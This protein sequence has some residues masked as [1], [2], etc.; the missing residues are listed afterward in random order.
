MVDILIHSPTIDSPGKVKDDYGLRFLNM[1]MINHRD[2]VFEALQGGV[3]RGTRRCLAHLRRFSPDL[4]EPLIQQRLML[5]IMYLFAVASSREAARDRP[6]VWRNLWG[7]PAA[8]D[9]LIDTV[10]GM[11]TQRPSAHT[12]ASIGR[13]PDIQPQAKT[14][15][16]KDPS[17]IKQP[18]SLANSKAPF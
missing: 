9:N 14:T 18:R 3:D 7:H 1:A 4:P 5:V 10:E 16:A 2:L 8:R 6:D 13:P 12:L 11:L 15:S 17:P